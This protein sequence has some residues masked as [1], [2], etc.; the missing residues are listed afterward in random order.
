M[1]Y[2]AFLSYSRSDEK[3]AR[4]LHGE[5]DRY[6]TPKSL[7]H[8]RGTRGPIPQS[9]HP[10]FRDRTDLSGGGALGDHITAALDESECLIV[11]CSPSAKLSEWVNHEV[12]RFVDAGRIDRIF[13]VIVEGVPDVPDIEAAYFPPALH[14]LGLLAIDLRDFRRADG[15]LVG[16]GRQIG[17][18]KL[19]A[20]LLSVGLDQLVRRERRRQRVLFGA[21]AGV[22]LLFLG[23]AISASAAGWIA[24]QNAD[25]ASR[26]RTLAETNA[27]EAQ[28]QKGVALVN[29]RRASESADLAE[30]R[31]DSEILARQEAEE[32]RLLA[33]TREKEARTSLARMFAATAFQES[34][35]GSFAAAGRAAAIGL[36]TDSN[37]LECRLQLAAALKSNHLVQRVRF[38]PTRITAT[39][40]TVDGDWLFAADAFDNVYA[41]ET[42]NLQD[43]Q[44]VLKP[45][46]QMSGIVFSRNGTHV[47]S[48]EQFDTFS[49]RTLP[50]GRSLGEVTTDN[51]RNIYF[52]P[53]GRYVAVGSDKDL[54]IF[55]TDRLE[56]SKLIVG[57]KGPGR[58][59]FCEICDAAAI[60]DANGLRIVSLTNGATSASVAAP[61][62]P[63]SFEESSDGR[64]IIYRAVDSKNTTLIL[65]DLESGRIQTRLAPRGRAS[66]RSAYFPKGDQSVIIGDGQGKLVSFPLETFSEAREEDIALDWLAGAVESIRT[67]DGYIFAITDGDGVNVYQPNTE[68]SF[69]SKTSEGPVAELS[70][71]SNGQEFLTVH[72]NG[73]VSRWRIR[74]EPDFLRYAAL[75]RSPSLLHPLITNDSAYLVSDVSQRALA[76]YPEA[77]IVIISLQDGGG[78]S[79]VSRI[80]CNRTPAGRCIGLQYVM[81]S[82]NS[83]VVTFAQRYKLSVWSAK[84]GELLREI[85]LPRVHNYDSEY[86][87]LVAAQAA[88]LVAMR[89]GHGVVVW[90]VRLGAVVFSADRADLFTKRVLG[91]LVDFVLNDTAILVAY[92]DGSTFCWDIASGSLKWS[93]AGKGVRPR[94]LRVSED[95]ETVA[96]GTENETI[97]VLSAR[98]GMTLQSIDL[99]RDKRS[100]Y[101]LAPEPFFSPDGKLLIAQMPDGR[102]LYE[103]SRNYLVSCA[104]AERPHT[105]V[106]SSSSG[107]FGWLLQGF[108]LNWS[109]VERMDVFE[110]P[111]SSLMEKFCNQYL[112]GVGVDPAPT[113]TG[114]PELDARCRQ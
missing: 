63:S 47:A 27:D 43:I 41:I 22:S 62:F 3:T 95:G 53:N 46:R 33:T 4:W 103:W 86:S 79:S 5:L 45:K 48:R 18:L 102:C 80:D 91:N 87:S 13:P 98:T 21:L 112:Q 100:K 114:G 70:V 9:L 60:V 93:T 25:E 89:H 94:E 11:L 110:A 83:A 38:S 7:M 42:N 15:R 32:Q 49:I 59:S 69:F 104:D 14:S 36:L 107:G 81:L 52:S 26:Q 20:G 29:A 82:D 111:P 90:N 10:I 77:D 24:L 64:F 73:F 16:D 1:K 61:A 113:E 19:I 109:V 23:L 88:P 68:W 6:R 66:V 50:D 75:G 105:I 30:A 51:Y 34:L 17:K 65:A 8:L 37:C 71:Q 78:G 12:S 39:S 106:K 31:A 35:R 76:E 85:R 40:A 44:L 92:D 28:R 58:V 84:D 54:T 99:S 67:Q 57:T 74:P 55:E 56:E 101:S 97:E 108:F 72:A 2:R 96:I